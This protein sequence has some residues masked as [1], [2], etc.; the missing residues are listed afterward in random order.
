VQKNCVTYGSNI[1][2]FQ[3]VY[4][5]WLNNHQVIC[6]NSGK[7]QSKTRIGMSHCTD[8]SWTPKL[9]A[10]ERSYRREYHV[11]SCTI[12]FFV[13]L[14]VDTWRRRA[15]ISHPESQQEG[16]HGWE[17]VLQF[18]CT[19]YNMSN[20]RMD[21]E[22]PRILTVVETTLWSA[23]VATNIAE[24]HSEVIWNTRKRGKRLMLRMG[25]GCE[26]QAGLILFSS[27]QKKEVTST[28]P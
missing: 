10:V 13:F 24:I 8:Y 18:F 23:C 9:P 1:L 26:M 5:I 3:L 20:L 2:Q 17:L 11:E 14:L 25:D 6:Y 21:A 12:D 19:D 27:G 28:T 15:G 7:I 4:H 16:P 22:F